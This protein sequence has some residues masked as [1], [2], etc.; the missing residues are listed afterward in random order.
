MS[1]DAIDANILA[2]MSFP[3]LLFYVF[4]WLYQGGYL[5]KQLGGFVFVRQYLELESV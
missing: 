4:Q 1:N 2:E 5:R 3:D